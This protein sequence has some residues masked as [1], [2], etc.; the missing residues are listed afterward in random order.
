MNKHHIN[1]PLI[2]VRHAFFNR[3]GG[4]SKAPFASLNAS[5][6]VG[7][8]KK[9]VQENRKIICKSLQIEHLISLNQVHGKKVIIID[10]NNLSQVNNQEADAMIT[11]LANVG[12]LIQH[13]DCQPVL[14]FDPIKQVVAAT[15][16]G[17]RG[18]VVNILAKTVTMM[19]RHYSCSPENIKVVI[20]PSL[21]PCCAEFINYQQELPRQLHDFQVKKNHFDFWQ[22]SRRQLQE[23]GIKDEN[24]S[25]LEI[26]S[27]CDDNFFSYRRSKKEGSGIT[28]RNC[29]VIAL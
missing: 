25:S 10:K 3:H 21:G 9:D 23:K 12:L 7:D 14:F 29:S 17:W 18:S 27:K 8:D 5:Y 11:N 2:T 16:N 1:T 15:H 13:A 22:I 20:G 4:K 24:I 28:G 19:E 6:N 26:C